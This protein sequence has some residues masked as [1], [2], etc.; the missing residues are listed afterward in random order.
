MNHLL[1]AVC[2][3]FL[4]LATLLPAQEGEKPKPAEKAAEK[5]AETKAPASQAPA[6]DDAVTA[7]DSAILAIDGFIA[8]KKIDKKASGWKTKLPMP[9]KLTFDPTHDYFWHLETEHGPIKVRYFA[10]TAPMHVSSGIFLSRLGFYD[11]LGFH[12]VIPRFMAQGGDPLGTGSGGP[13]YQF[14]GEFEGGRKHD[15]PGLLSMANTGMPTTDGSQFF[16]TFVPTPHLD[17]KHTIWGEVVDGMATLKALESKG[18]PGGQMAK[19]LKI[20]RT[21]I[22]VAEKAKPANE[23]KDEKAGGE[24]K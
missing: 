10:D 18:T 6:K 17:G 7:K 11:D 23:K 15:R 8:E 22:T 20:T 21:W 19:A 13:G 12:R 24:K 3:P 4:G 9:P 1:R 2:V 16:L 5:P 14:D